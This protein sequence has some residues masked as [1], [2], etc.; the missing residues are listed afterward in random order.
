V[1]SPFDLALVFFMDS[2][3]EAAYDR[4]KCDPLVCD[5][6]LEDAISYYFSL[7]GRSIDKLLD[8]FAAGGVTWKTAPKAYLKRHI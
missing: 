2:S 5:Q 4:V 1:F 6:D 7:H 8:S 3:Q